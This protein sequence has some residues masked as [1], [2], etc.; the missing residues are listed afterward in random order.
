MRARSDF[1]SWPASLSVSA[2]TFGGGG[3]G[4]VPR[5]FSRIHLPRST[6]DVRFG[7]DVTV[8]MLPWPSRP[9]RSSFGQRHA[10]ELAAVDV[11]NPVVARQPLVDE[12]VVGVEQ[13]EDAAVFAHDA[14]EEQLRLGAERLRAARC[15]S[16][17][18][19]PASACG[20]SGC[21]ASATG[22][23]SC[24]RARATSDPRASA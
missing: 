11:R 2:G 24:R 8:R 6:G 20:S 3:G 14:L 18:S 15:R 10:A 7:Y 23:R 17:G 5:M 13:V 9:R 16:S 12:R 19:R 4:G 21:A 1:G 22:W